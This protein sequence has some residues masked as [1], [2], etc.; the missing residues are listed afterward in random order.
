MLCPRQLLRLKPGIK[1]LGASLLVLIAC[2]T[3]GTDIDHTLVFANGMR[4]DKEN[5]EY[6]NGMLI[7]PNRPALA[8]A[9]PAP[10][11]SVSPTQ[12]Q[13][14]S[15]SEQHQKTCA[16][17]ANNPNL[18]SGYAAEINRH[19]MVMRFNDFWKKRCAKKTK[20]EDLWGNKTTDVM[21][22]DW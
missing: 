1:V 6:I 17:V 4:Y 8:C 3:F 9:T 18:P 7:V 11:A 21:L 22:N 15:I 12:S 14:S 13:V 2:K 20:C 10:V 16:F 19:D 5:K